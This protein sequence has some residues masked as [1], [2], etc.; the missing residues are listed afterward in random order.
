MSKKKLKIIAIAFLA[1]MS[2]GIAMPAQAF[3]PGFGVPVNDVQ[4][5]IK[6]TVL[7]VLARKLASEVLGRISSKVIQTINT[8]G[9]DGGA[10]FV[11]DWRQ[12][13]VGSS[14]RG[15]NVFRAQLQYAIDK[16]IL[17]PGVKDALGTLFNSKNGKL[18]LPQGKDIG[19]LGGLL[20]AGNLESFQSRVKCTIP[21]AIYED[22]QKDFKKGGGWD[23]WLRIIQP[24]N[25]YYGL[26]ELSLSELE[27]QRAVEQKADEGETRSSGFLGKRDGCAG[28]GINAQCVFF[29]ETLTPAQILGSSAAKTIDSKFDFITS[30]DELSEIIIAVIQSA[31]SHLDS[32][33]DRKTGTTVINLDDFVPRIEAEGS[34]AD[35]QVFNAC[36]AT[37]TSGGSSCDATQMTG[38]EFVAC[39][40]NFK[41]SC[42][43][44]C[45][46]QDTP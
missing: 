38:S 44:Q 11:L 14:Q 29:G 2:A 23:T 36:Y 20:R 10:A 19:S 16:N 25:N 28:E 31:F 26:L 5:N 1:A 22:F 3:I 13:V 41:D 34:S 30:S 46:T 17:C 4:N 43:G 33:L 40:N 9:R 24:Q 32:F 8:K 39:E 18:A 21:A 27:T 45:S 42:R 37:C 12:F 6:E 15:E 35:N 7:D